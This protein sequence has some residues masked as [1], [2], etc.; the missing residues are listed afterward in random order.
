MR[1]RLI[2]NPTATTTNTGV[3]D[4]LAG[5]LADELELSVVGTRERLHAADLARQA[6]ADDVDAVFVLGGDGT[7]NEVLQGLA[8]T[9][10]ALGLLP[11]GGTNVLARA[12]GLPRHAATAASIQLE[13]LHAG[14]DQRLGLGEVNGRLFGFQAGVGLDAGIV[15]RVEDHPGMKRVLGQLAFILLG[16]REWATSADRRDP[17]CVVEEV[18]AAAGTVTP[19]TND[20]DPRML[21]TVA[22][23]APYTYLGPR[24]FRLI[25]DAGP[26]TALDVLMA[27]PLP[28]V[29][30]L[31]AVMRAFVDASHVHEPGFDAVHDV[32]RVTVRMHRAVPLMVDGDLVDHVRRAAFRHRPGILRVLAD[33]DAASA[34]GST[35]TRVA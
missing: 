13:R 25:P 24:P 10:V 17:A 16:L 29:R 6:V 23:L 1:A 2:F 14:H 18:H 20:D 4:A 11:G 27:A 7:A 28:T 33:V 22:N 5:L 30:V 12:L 32:D 8:G 34:T 35:G 15:Q 3:R 31:G 21:V 26:G 9:D 19:W